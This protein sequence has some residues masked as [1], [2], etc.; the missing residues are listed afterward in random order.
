LQ[1]AV[2]RWLSA[3]RDVAKPPVPRARGDVT[4]DD[5][6]T[7]PPEERHEATLRWAASV[8]AAWSDRQALARAW[9]EAAMDD[10]R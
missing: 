8:W 7:V 6:I 2:Q 1:R 10:R 9:V 5:V 4:V 3:A